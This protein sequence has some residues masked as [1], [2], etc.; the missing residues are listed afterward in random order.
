MF[1][2][3]FSEL[4]II[5]VIALIVIGPERL[6][7]VARTVGTWLGKLNRYVAQV[8]QDIDRDMQLEE[9]RK[10]QQQMK[11]TA[12]KYEILASETGQELKREVDQVDRVMQAMAVTDGGLALQEFGK[13]KEEQ[14]VAASLEKPATPNLASQQP[15]TGNTPMSETPDINS[16][17][18]SPP[19]P[20]GEPA[21]SLVADTPFSSRLDDEVLADDLTRPLPDAT[22]AN[23]AQ[24]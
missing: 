9:L 10:L 17:A 21:P 24:P 23:Q 14:A 3:A 16:S 2:I 4:L 19:M 6:P 5:G 22:K 11:D 1:D 18:T 7:K 13:I 20:P 12:Q 15:V 8:K